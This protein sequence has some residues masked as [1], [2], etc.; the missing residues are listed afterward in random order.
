[1]E[2]RRA[3]L[4]SSQSAAFL[5][6]SAATRIEAAAG[7]VLAVLLGLMG[8]LYWNN[9]MLPLVAVFV[10][11]AAAGESRWVAVRSMLRGIPFASRAETCGPCDTLSPRGAIP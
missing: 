10:C 8:L 4:R 11:F 5:D 2:C 1:M 7:Q 3:T 9:L 6:Y